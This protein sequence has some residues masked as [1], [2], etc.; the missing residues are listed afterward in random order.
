MGKDEDIDEVEVVEECPWKPTTSED[1]S[2][3]YMLISYSLFVY[4]VSEEVRS[5]RTAA[6]NRGISRKNLQGLPIRQQTLHLSNTESTLLREL[7]KL[8]YI[9]SIALS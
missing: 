4:E 5:P 7:N 3:I 6:A 8:I 2:A 1:R 9:H